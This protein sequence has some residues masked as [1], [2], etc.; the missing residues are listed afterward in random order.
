MDDDPLTAALDAAE[1]VGFG[2]ARGGP[3]SRDDE[4]EAAA[5]ERAVRDSL[6]RIRAVVE[7]G[8]AAGDES[9]M[10][11]GFWYALHQLTADDRR[12]LGME[13]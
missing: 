6:A 13:P 5:A 7:A 11:P 1:S 3:E 2:A 12:L 8:E 10:P 9:R 4:P